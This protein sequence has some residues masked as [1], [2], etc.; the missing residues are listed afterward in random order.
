MLM[1]P[2]PRVK[3]V[4][5]PKHEV[6]DRVD[7]WAL[8]PFLR[9]AHLSLLCTC[10]TRGASARSAKHSASEVPQPHQVNTY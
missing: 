6:G 2:A 10:S 7:V 5:K 1:F 9:Y 3:P 4:D 8:E